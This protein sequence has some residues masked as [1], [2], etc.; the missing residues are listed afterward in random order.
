MIM[1]ISQ[2][3]DKAALYSDHPR[4]ELLQKFGQSK[5]AKMYCDRKDG[6]AVH[7]GYIVGGLWWTFY[8]ME[9]WE[10]KV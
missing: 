6:S 9:R 1:A 8:K 7:I 2:Y 4:K 3:G 5:A 10:G